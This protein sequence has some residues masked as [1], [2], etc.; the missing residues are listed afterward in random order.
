MDATQALTNYTRSL[1]LSERLLKD[2][3]ES[4]Q[5]ARDVSLA[6]E[7]LGG[8]LNR[9]G[10]TGDAEK[11]LVYYNRSLVLR[12]RIL[13]QYPESADAVRGVSV[14]LIDLGD[15]LDGRGLAGDSAIALTNYYRS[16]ELRE[17]LF[18]D[19]PKSVMA[20]RDVSGILMRIGDFL[21]RRKHSGDLNLALS[22]YTRCTE[23]LEGVFKDNPESVQAARDVSLCFIRL[24]DF[25]MDRGLPGDSALA[26]TNYIRCNDIR[27]KLWQANPESTEAARDVAV[28]LN[29][30]AD[31]LARRGMPGDSLLALSNYTRC[32]QIFERLF[33]ANPDHGEIIRELA[34]SFHKLGDFFTDR[35]LSEDPNK[36]L[37]NYIR[38]L[39]L[40]E[41]LLTANPDS[42]QA[43]RGVA[44][45]ANEI[46]LHLARRGLPGD[47]EVAF[48]NYMRSF[49]LSDRL[50]TANPESGEAARVMSI[51]LIH[52]GDF[53]NESRVPEDTALAL[54]KFAR[55]NILLEGLF[56]ANPDSA[57]ATRDVAVSLMKLGDAFGRRATPEN[58][59]IAYTNYTRS[60]VLM[61][62][63]LMADPD[64]ADK[65]RD[66]AGSL[67]NLG[68]FLVW[69]GQPDDA[70]QALNHYS[71]SLDILERVLKANPD[72][73]RAAQEVALSRFKLGQLTGKLGDSLSAQKHL[74]ACYDILHSRLSLGAELDPNIEA[75]YRQLQK[76]YGQQ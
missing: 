17:R 7:K 16:L 45:T 73:A 27:K 23:V 43:A 9:R 34:L 61:E 31:L 62:R 53:L 21:S 67:H 29:N 56:K 58:T 10:L 65:A 57:E 42:A 4:V 39:E 70:V 66:L 50:L 15:F 32:N 1:E 2:N 41:R 24:G 69:R 18:E 59:P 46:G 47:R 38:S 11:A 51:C 68:N 13:Q 52:L 36:A 55:A 63:L 5:A 37:P 19:H 8:F 22:N 40:R 72:S 54:K 49:E 74:Q 14:S 60:V 26:M 25:L 12:D 20:A 76:A 64:S 35:R 75:I 33:N 48:T 3:P 28:G 6:L 71:R 30:L 44:L